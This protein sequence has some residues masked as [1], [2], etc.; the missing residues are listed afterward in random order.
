M[1]QALTINE[2]T[3]VAAINNYD[4]TL[5]LPRFLQSSGIVPSD[6]NLNSEPIVNNQIVQTV[7][8]NGVNVIAQSNRCLFAENI[9]NKEESLVESPQVAKNYV[10]T[11]PR[12]DYQAIGINLRGYIKLGS[13]PDKARQEFFA[14][15]LVDGSWQQKGTKAMEAELNLNYTFDDKRLTLSI[16]NGLLRQ[17][18]TEALPIILFSGNF[19]YNLSEQPQK[20]RV[21]KI[22]EIITNWQ[23]D[24]HLFKDVIRD[25]PLVTIEEKQLAPALA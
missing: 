8:S 20:N 12:L 15:L 24:L 11:L 1:N 4:L 6:W 23:S 3:I 5:C 9:E 14:G 2:L 18:E 17:P 25:F 7:Y 19:S 22:Q 10:Q 13:E 21:E 16:N